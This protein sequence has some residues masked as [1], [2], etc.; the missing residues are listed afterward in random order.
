MTDPLRLGKLSCLA[1][2]AVSCG[3][4]HNGSPADGNEVGPLDD[5]DVIFMVPEGDVWL[6]DVGWVMRGVVF[7]FGYTED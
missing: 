7:S 1:R 6:D 5:V 2:F 4:E 3:V